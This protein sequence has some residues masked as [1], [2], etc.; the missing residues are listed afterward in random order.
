MLIKIIL[1]IC[2]DNPHA[3]KCNLFPDHGDL[4]TIQDQGKRHDVLQRVNAKRFLFYTGIS[5]RF[6][7][8]WS[9]RSGALFTF[10]T[11]AKYTTLTEKE[12][13]I[14]VFI[15]AFSKHRIRSTGWSKANYFIITGTKIFRSSELT[16]ESIRN[17]DITLN[18]RPK[19]TVSETV[20]TLMRQLDIPIVISEYA[21]FIEEIFSQ[22][23]TNSN[24]YTIY[25]K[26]Y[27]YHHRL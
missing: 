15:V 24:N 27:D 22:N 23:I 4:T 26:K 2:E 8:I 19:A 25:L 6:S 3:N 12:G 7:N 9:P 20:S 13:I 11:G 16:I 17:K 21:Y 18:F 10:L 1:L 14:C 5:I